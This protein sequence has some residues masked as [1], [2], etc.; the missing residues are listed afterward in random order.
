M[1]SSRSSLNTTQD[2]VQGTSTTQ[3]HIPPENDGITNMGYSCRNLSF[4]ITPRVVAV[5]TYL[6]Q[7]CSLKPTFSLKTVSGTQIIGRVSMRPRKCRSEL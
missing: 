4:M 7:P 2:T 5:H 3:R 6:A 1:L